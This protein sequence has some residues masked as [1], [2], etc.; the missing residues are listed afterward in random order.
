MPQIFHPSFN[1]LSKVS[2]FGAVFFLGAAV[3]GWDMLLRSPYN[4][5]VDV[6]RE[7]PVPF[8]HKHHVAGLGIDCRFCHSSVEDSSFAGIPPTKTCMGCH[9]MVWK[10]AAVLAPVRESFQSDRPIP[11]TRVHDLPDFA[12]FDHSIHVKKGIGCTT[13]HGQ[14]DE[15]PLTW[16]TATLNMDWCLDCHRDPAANVRPRARVFDVHWD[17]RELDDAQRAALAASY[18]VKSRLDCSTCH[19]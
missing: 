13:C 16:R 2:I 11:W 14:V 10:D 3:W 8:S 1:T 7:Q 12:Y 19:R 17:A 4:T 5:Q 6:A 18:D 9:S 15:M